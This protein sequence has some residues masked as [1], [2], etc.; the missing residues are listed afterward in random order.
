MANVIAMS[1]GSSGDLGVRSTRRKRLCVRQLLAHSVEG[2]P[3]L[4]R[5]QRDRD[6]GDLVRP[7]LSSPVPPLRSTTTAYRAGARTAASLLSEWSD[8][9]AQH[10]NHPWV[11]A[12]VPLNESRGVADCERNVQQRA[13]IGA[14][15]ATTDALDGTRPVSAND[16]WETTAGD[17]VGIHDYEQDPEILRERL[18]IGR[19]SD[20]RRSDLDGDSERDRAVVLS[21]F[22]G[23]A[24]ATDTDGRALGFGTANSGYPVSGE[25]LR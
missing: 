7:A 6:T 21:E 9:V 8:V 22:G 5:A 16:G 18:R 4:S 11:I 12:W 14:L 24:L 15:R 20:G 1:G 2:N 13:L 10:R 17:I 25:D 23:I 3:G 19:R